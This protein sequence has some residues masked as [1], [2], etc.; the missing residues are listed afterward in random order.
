MTAKTP[1]CRV[2]ILLSERRHFDS[3]RIEEVSCHVVCAFMM[4]VGFT[5]PHFAA[6]TS[7]IFSDPR[8][9]A[10]VK[11]RAWDRAT[12]RYAMRRYSFTPA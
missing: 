4:R 3:R 10:A 11:A 7:R 2:Q 8:Q 12:L 5:T 9:A 1:D 6:I